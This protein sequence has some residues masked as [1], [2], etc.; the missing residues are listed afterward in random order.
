MSLLTKYTD[1][2]TV[3]IK[4]E[5]AWIPDQVKSWPEE[6]QERLIKVMMAI[7]LRSSGQGKEMIELMLKG[8]TT[9]D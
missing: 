3:I 4:D 7:A 9:N 8:E 6:D 1:K 2:I 5:S